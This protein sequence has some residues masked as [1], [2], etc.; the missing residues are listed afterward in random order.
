MSS[1][2]TVSTSMLPG[3][4]TTCPECGETAL[5]A[6]SDGWSTNF[7]CQGCGRCWRCELGYISQVDP[8]TCPGA[9]T[10]TSA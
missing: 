10:A 9:P 7:L 4:P 2:E 1:A 3:P 5:E 8:T 6:V